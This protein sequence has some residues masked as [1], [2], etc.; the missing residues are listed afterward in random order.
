MQ[1]PKEDSQHVKT[2]SLEIRALEMIAHF[3]PQI[4]LARMQRFSTS[5]KYHRLVHRL[6][7]QP[8]PDT[9]LS[10]TATA[11]PFSFLGPLDPRRRSGRDMAWYL[12][13]GVFL[14]SLA[15]LERAMAPGQYLLGAGD[16]RLKQRGSRN[17]QFT[18]VNGRARSIGRVG[19][20]EG[21]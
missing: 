15:S 16:Y 7:S 4:R 17:V 10:P 3:A 14:C 8:G 6:Q 21:Y 18:G 11:T 9:T 13:A 2:G 12:G 20:A 5:T 1:T 19:W